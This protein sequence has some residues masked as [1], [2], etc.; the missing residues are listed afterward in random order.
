MSGATQ[1]RLKRCKVRKKC[2]LPRKMTPGQEVFE[3]LGFI[4]K[5]T[6]D[7]ALL[8][9]KLPKGWIVEIV[10]SST[11]YGNF[12]DEKGRKR[13]GYCYGKENDGRSC[14]SMWLNTR[15]HAIYLDSTT[16]PYGY[17]KYG[18][19]FTVCVFDS[20]RSSIVFSAGEC[21]EKNTVRYGK[22]FKKAEAYLESTYPDW[23]DVTKYWD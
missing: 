8:D 2:A 16:P 23:K 3:K 6:G 7:A 21:L 19:T 4:F 11:F 1:N 22:L 17:K 14:W 20:L 5:D 10:P 18:R 9:A 15:Y 13:G 12:I